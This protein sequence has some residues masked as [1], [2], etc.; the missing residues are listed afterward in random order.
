MFMPRVTPLSLSLVVPTP[1]N[2][3]PEVA[4]VGEATGQVVVGDI[5]REPPGFRPREELLAEL[6]RAGEASVVHT[7]TGIRGAVASVLDARARAL[8][9]SGDRVAIRDIPDQ[10]A[11][12][13]SNM[14]GPAD[15]AGKELAEL[16]LSLRFWALYY[17]NELGDSV[18]QAIAIGEQLA[19]DFER[20]LGSNHVDSLNARN[21]LAIA[22]EDA[23][24]T[25]EA[26]AVH[27]Q[28]L[29]ARERV[30]GPSH[31][32]T[33]GSRNNLANAYRAAGRVPE[34]PSHRG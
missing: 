4:S 17:L 18:S 27:E 1:G 12:L 26:I 32:S 34:G 14:A 2:C 5:P 28:V 16:L 33:L 7:V 8:R 30:L 31:P 25:A 23:G 10:V 3:P 21:S 6:D 19:A 24:R 9:G 22:Y 20:A 13:Q 29:E 15:M 11:A